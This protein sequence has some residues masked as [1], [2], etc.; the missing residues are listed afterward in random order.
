[1][2]KRVFGRKLKRDA[3][4]RKALFYGLMTD[5]VLKEKIQTTEEKAKAVRGQME[6]L[7]TKA[8]RKEQDAISL[9]QPYLSTE[10]VE[11]VLND[12]SLRFKERPGGYLRIVKLGSRFG[13]N[14]RMAIIEWVEKT[15]ARV[16]KT[17]EKVPVRQVQGKEKAAKAVKAAQDKPV[18]KVAVKPAVKKAVKAKP[19]RAGQGKKG[20][21]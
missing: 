2:R 6:K 13:D 1:M 7:I 18:K 3:N 21:K 17:A 15:S 10:A 8:K 19:V 12:L 5:L 20:S 14:A 9:L 16:A 4:E 11:K